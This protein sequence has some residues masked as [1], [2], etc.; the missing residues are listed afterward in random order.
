MN[1]G[2]KVRLIHSKEEGIVVRFL[3]NDMI[4]VEI[5]AGFKLPILRKEL[6]IVS[7]VENNIFRPLTNSIPDKELPQSNKYPEIRADKGIFLAFFPVSEGKV[8]LYLINNTDW[9]IPFSCTSEQNQKSKGL[10]AGV[11]EPK[12]FKMADKDLA[13]KDFDD[14]GVIMFEGLFYHKNSFNYKPILTKKM[15]L[16]ANTFFNSKSLA[17][18]LSKE[19]YMSQLDIEESQALKIDP[20]E[21]KHSMLGTSTQELNAKFVKPSSEI[22]LHI[23]QLL[24]NYAHLSNEQIINT[25]LSAFEK[26]LESAIAS[27][28]DEIIFIHGVGNG[29]LKNLIHK[30]LSGHK[31]VEWYKDAQKEKFGFGATKVK[32]K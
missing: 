8:S 14:W 16:R 7:K 21:I 32:I 28:M 30:R 25:Q 11:L 23:E 10:L 9:T 26:N 1:I 17:P 27:G 15:R 2:D 29:V 20:Q 18:L 12:T 5:E 4:E 6:A 24:T 19:C 13:M 31:N 22:D 3:K